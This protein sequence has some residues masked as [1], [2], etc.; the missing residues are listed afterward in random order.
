MLTSNANNSFDGGGFTID[1]NHYGDLS[2]SGDE[3]MTEN[4][5]ID[6]DMFDES[7]DYEFFND[8]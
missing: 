3:E 5:N 8:E 1:D 6:D 4:K 7:T 2:D